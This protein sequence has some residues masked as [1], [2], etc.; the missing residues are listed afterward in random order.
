MHYQSLLDRQI[1]PTFGGKVLAQVTP[2]QVAD[3]H[4]SLDE[5]RPTLRA[6]AYGLL[7]AIVNTAIAEDECTA[8]PCRVRGASASKRVAAVRPASLDE[9][10]ALVAAMPPRYRVMTLLAA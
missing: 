8:N 3:W 9:L 7:K 5:S 10:G 2:R 1:L 4:H 6:H